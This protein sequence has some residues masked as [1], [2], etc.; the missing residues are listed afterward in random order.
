MMSSRATAAATRARSPRAGV[1]RR[2]DGRRVV[3][4][5]QRNL[6]RI[7]ARAASSSSSS[8]EA[9]PDNGNKLLVLGGTG[10]VGG[11]VIERALEGGY[12]VVSISRRGA[13]SASARG[14]TSS[15]DGR[16]DWRVGDVTLPSTVRDVLAEGGFVGCVHAV[17]MLLASDLNAYA[18]GSGSVPSAGSTYDDV[19]RKSA[20]HAAD[21]VAEFVKPVD[22][23][24]ASD[25]TRIYTTSKRPPPF[26]FVSAAEAKWDFRAP[27]EWLEEYLVAKR[28]V[29][30]KLG[31]MTAAGA[32]R[33]TI[34]R[35]SLVYAF[36]KP[37]SF[38]AVAAFVIGNAIGLPFVD[39]PV[40]AGALATAAV[41]AVKEEA[42]EGILD[43]VGIEELS[44]DASFNELFELN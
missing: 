5:V 17:G 27:V 33:A 26:V 35:P 31:A 14:P 24:S 1:A 42:V 41:R 12:S 21:A 34:L 23:T 22:F 8:S 25:G 28:A 39:R 20:F 10:F 7:P 32:L 15:L 13:P 19:T 4:D 36:D 29:E 6:T 30:E 18:S 11:N 40:T 9:A 16:V 37:A 3:R 43:Y 38:P 44:C 2:F